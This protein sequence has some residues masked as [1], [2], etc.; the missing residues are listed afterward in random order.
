VPRGLKSLKDNVWSWLSYEL[1]YNVV[2][3][4]KAEKDK[5]KL[6]VSL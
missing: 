5:V 4:N 2:K 1:P 6:L 3:I